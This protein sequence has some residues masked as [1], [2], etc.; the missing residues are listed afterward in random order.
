MLHGDPLTATPERNTFLE[1]VT[2][3]LTRI[4]RKR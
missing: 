1:T 2:P 4:A 3:F